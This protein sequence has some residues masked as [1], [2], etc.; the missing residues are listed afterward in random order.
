MNQFDHLI[1]INNYYFLRSYAKKFFHFVPNIDNGQCKRLSGIAWIN[2]F[3]RLFFKLVYEEIKIIEV[4]VKLLVIFMAIVAFPI[5]SMDPPVLAENDS[6]ILCDTILNAL[7]MKD[8]SL[9]LGLESWSNERLIDALPDD[10][11]KVGND[12][13][14]A[15]PYFLQLALRGNPYTIGVIGRMLDKGEVFERNSKDAMLLLKGASEKNCPDATY[16]LM[17]KYLNELKEE[18]PDK[19]IARSFALKVY[20]NDELRDENYNIHYANE[21]AEA[22]K[23]IEEMTPNYFKQVRRIIYVR[24][25]ENLEK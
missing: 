21:R 12:G 15:A 2:P 23:L 20:W 8:P 17:K 25:Q 24:P 11:E 7:L 9:N 14:H 16:F 10:D 3:T 5:W 4:K 13:K 19:K 1:T 6:K 22:R 18:D